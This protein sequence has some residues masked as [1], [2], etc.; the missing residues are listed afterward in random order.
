MVFVQGV[1]VDPIAISRAH[2]VV[3]GFDYYNVVVAKTL[4]VFEYSA[5]LYLPAFA[6]AQKLYSPLLLPRVVTFLVH[7][8]RLLL[9]L[10]VRLVVL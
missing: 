6:S 7:V 3:A 4:V 2:S 9:N 10:L 8:E 1:I 5:D